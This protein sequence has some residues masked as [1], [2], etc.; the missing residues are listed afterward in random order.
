MISEMEEDLKTI[1]TPL[2]KPSFSNII[3]DSDGNV[4]F[5][6]IPEEKTLMFFMFGYITKLDN[7]QQNVPLYAMITN[8]IL[9]PIKWF[10][11]MVIY[12]DYR[13]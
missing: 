6:E 3:K 11:R 7:L 12:V 10:L 1:N 5:F 8:S 2:A 9:V 13:H 4:L